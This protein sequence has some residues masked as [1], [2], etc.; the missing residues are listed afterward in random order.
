MMSARKGSEA[1]LPTRIELQPLSLLVLAAPILPPQLAPDGYNDACWGLWERLQP[2]RRQLQS[3][4]EFE[5]ELNDLYR[6]LKAGGIRNGVLV[7]GEQGAAILK[8]KAAL[9]RV[10]AEAKARG[11]LVDG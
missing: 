5:Q 11:L 7:G 1:R 3:G 8:A 2:G 4:D 9:D 10:Q 6:T